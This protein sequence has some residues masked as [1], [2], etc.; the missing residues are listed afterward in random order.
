MLLGGCSHFQFKVLQVCLTPRLPRSRNNQ[1]TI[2][3][4]YYTF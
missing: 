2:G 1:T 3:M 4:V